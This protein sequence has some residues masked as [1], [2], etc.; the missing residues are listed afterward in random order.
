MLFEPPL[1]NASFEEPVVKPN[2]SSSDITV[3]YDSGSYTYTVWA[4]HDPSTY[5]PADGD[6]WAELGNAKYVYQQIGYWVPNAD[7]NIAVLL[8][9]K[10]GA[11]FRGAKISLWAGG[12]AACAGDGTDLSGIGAVEV[13]TSGLIKPSLSGAS[14][15]EVTVT[16]NTGTGYSVG[17]PLWL[18]IAQGG[19]TGRTLVDNVRIVR[20]LKGAYGYPDFAVFADK[21]QRMD[22]GLCGG[23]DFNGDSKVDISDLAVFADEWLSAGGNTE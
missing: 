15:E 16:L 2:G 3:W 11:A 21:W 23:A 1:K 19:G 13:A 5:P 7:F 4:D 18:R 22:C 17:S 6:N 9:S 10:A 20:R 14:S 8:G 12:D